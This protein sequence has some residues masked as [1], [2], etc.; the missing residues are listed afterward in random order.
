[1]YSSQEQ[2]QECET[3]HVV[4]PF[5]FLENTWAFQKEYGYSLWK[6]TLFMCLKR[7]ERKGIGHFVGH[8]V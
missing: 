3:Y 1:M 5:I 6:M 7:G 2:G 8:R 4:L